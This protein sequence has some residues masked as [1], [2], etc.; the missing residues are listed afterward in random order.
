VT[1]TPSPPERLTF[2]HHAPGTLGI[3]AIRPRLSWVVPTA[4]QGYRQ[5]RYEVRGRIVRAD[6]TVEELAHR[7]ESA[8]QV[9]VPWPGRELASRE[10][11]RLRVR[12]QGESGPWSG[13][14]D[15]AGV[16]VGLLD[17]ADWSAILVG[18]DDEDR[19][20][21]ERRPPLL[22]RTFD[23]PDGIRSARLYVTAHG[24]FEVELNGRRVGDHVLAPGWSS[25]RHLLRYATYDV[26]DHLRDGENALGAWLA[27]GWYRGHLGFDG[28]T[29]GV[30]G[31][32]VGLLAQLEVVT[33]EG[34]AV[35]LAT[36][37]TWRTAP[38]PITSS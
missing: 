33:D 16:E 24:V 7:V 29:W 18:P 30:F 1:T 34:R 20:P 22:R 10:A 28:G 15:E 21:A 35:V 9:L 37:G 36:D 13:W 19:P 26:T 12:V 4:P 5:A 25:Y 17:P 11:V 2:E 6:G 23:V 31:D 14:S 3:G 32:D 27:D 38:G 8:E